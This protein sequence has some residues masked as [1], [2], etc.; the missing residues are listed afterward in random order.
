MEWLNDLGLTMEIVGFIIFLYIPIRETFNIKLSGQKESKVTE[1]MD[2]K[3]VRI[4]GIL[5][6]F[7]GLILQ[8]NV[9][10]DLFQ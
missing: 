8:Y 10:R 1:R 6:V 3:S 2:R 5:L 4:F 7:L 9:I